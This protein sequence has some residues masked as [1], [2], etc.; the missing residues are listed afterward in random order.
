MENQVKLSSSIIIDCDEETNKKYLM[1]IENGSIYNLN[2]VAFFIV[3]SIKNEK[4]VDECIEELITLTNNQVL[5]EQ[6]IEDTNK[7][8]DELLLAGIVYE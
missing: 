6:I 7:Y 4:T 1:N 5:R 3:D 2:D 8:I